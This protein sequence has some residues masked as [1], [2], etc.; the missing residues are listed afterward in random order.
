MQDGTKRFAAV[1]EAG[2]CCNS[3]EVVEGAL[4]SDRES[5]NIG[6]VSSLTGMSVV[7]WISYLLLSN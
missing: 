6:S 5:F 2:S 7:G 3:A 4:D 1:R